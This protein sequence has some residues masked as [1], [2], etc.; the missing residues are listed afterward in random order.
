MLLA[1][2]KLKSIN[3]NN[4]YPSFALGKLEDTRHLILVL[5]TTLSFM[6][7]KQIEVVKKPRS[8]DYLLFVTALAIRLRNLSCLN[9]ILM[10]MQVISTSSA[11]HRS[12]MNVYSTEMVSLYKPFLFQNV[13]CL[14]LTS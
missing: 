8:S 1:F 2:K 11:L 7:Q 13:Y 12:A 3:L 5:N 10:Y 9:M 14:L 6:T 4:K